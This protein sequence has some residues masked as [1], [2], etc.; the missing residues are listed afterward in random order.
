LQEKAKGRMIMGTSSRCFIFIDRIDVSKVKKKKPGSA[1]TGSSTDT[2]FFIFVL[3]P[4]TTQFQL[5]I[6]TFPTAK[7]CEGQ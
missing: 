5:R 6:A 1:I 2:I 3:F 4:R 7:N